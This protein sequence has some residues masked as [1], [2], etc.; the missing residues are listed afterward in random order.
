M[1]TKSR[2]SVGPQLSKGVILLTFFEK[3]ESKALFG[4][5]KS[6][7]KICFERWRLPILI[8]E[9]ETPRSSFQGQSNTSQGYS[10]SSRYQNPALEY[11]R[12]N[13]IN[14]SRNEVQRRILSIIEV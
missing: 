11:E 3:R 8:N 6:Q 4:F 2:V 9:R 7:E 14:N 1:L 13:V 10:S 12:L 5:L